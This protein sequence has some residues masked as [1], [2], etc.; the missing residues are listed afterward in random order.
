MYGHKEAITLLREAEARDDLF[1]AGAR[2]DVE[3]VEEL[4][5]ANGNGDVQQ[6][7]RV[8]FAV[9]HMRAGAHGITEA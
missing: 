8:S 4:L 1:A 3:A 9:N 2:G 5:A 6:V 7:N